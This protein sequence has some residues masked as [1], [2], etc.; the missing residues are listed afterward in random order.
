MS[1]TQK[2]DDSSDT[3]RVDEVRRALRELI[4]LLAAATAKRLRPA[5]RGAAQ[6]TSHVADDIDGEVGPVAN[7]GYGRTS[8]FSQVRRGA[9]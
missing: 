7:R 2:P 8:T 1:T 4:S 3:T 9:H 5:A 6:T